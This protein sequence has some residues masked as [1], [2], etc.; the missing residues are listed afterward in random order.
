MVKYLKKKNES[1]IKIVFQFYKTN[2]QL[3]FLSTSF[4]LNVFLT[5]I[6]V[7]ELKPQQGS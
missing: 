5:E 3:L 2:T 7:L 6:L 4:Q 1:R